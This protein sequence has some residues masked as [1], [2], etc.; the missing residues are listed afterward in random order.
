VPAV[1]LFYDFSC[2]YAYLASTQI[3][4]LCARARAELVYKPF[5]LGG[6]FRALGAA[7]GEVARS[8]PPRARHNGLDMQRWAEHWGV[9][10]VM[11]ATHPN[12]TVLALRAALAAGDLGRASDALFGAYWAEGR[13]VSDPAVV[14]SALDRAGFD[15]EALVAR[16][17]DERIKQE[18]RARTDE[19]IARGVF[20][21]PTCFVNGQRFWGQDRLDFVARELG[22]PDETRVAS[23]AAVASFELWFDFSSPF[24]YLASTQIES[25][26]ARTGARAIW[27]PFLLGGLFREI[28]TP[29]VPLLAFSEAKRSYFHEDMQRWAQARGVPLRFPSRF[30][31]RTVLPLRTL[32]VAGDGAAA[33]SHALFR[34]C[35][36]DDRDISDSDEV[37]AICVETELDPRLVDQ[38]GTEDAKRALRAATDAAVARGLCGAPSFSVGDLLFWGQD[39]LAFVEKAIA[40]WRPR[41]D[42]VSG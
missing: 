40:G 2:P 20:G 3:R 5:L 26:E 32:L 36:V 25:L 13:D 9:P 7:A 34:A 24:A 27:R 4:A 16:A 1:E 28:G 14:A 19:A 22:L 10:L 17:G 38:A 31:I 18:L 42:S 30:P 41:A 6:L 35:W 37:R 21:A 23:P 33:L 12:R 15:G 11:P 29:D 8:S 39:R